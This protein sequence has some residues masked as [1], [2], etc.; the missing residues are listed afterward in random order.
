MLY[1]YALLNSN[2][3]ELTKQLCLLCEEAH[4]SGRP[5]RVDLT[6]FNAMPLFGGRT[7]GSSCSKVNG[8]HLDTQQ[9]FSR[10]SRAQCKQRLQRDYQGAIA[11]CPSA[12]FQL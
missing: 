8:Q 5:T 4:Q 7:Q 10:V 11:S 6:N 2:A 1:R 12:R 9:R 3:L